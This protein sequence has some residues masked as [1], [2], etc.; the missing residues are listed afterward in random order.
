[1]PGGEVIRPF[2]QRRNEMEQI[3]RSA[4]AAA[5]L[6]LALAGCQKVDEAPAPQTPDSEAPAPEIN[7][8]VPE[9]APAPQININPSEPAPAPEININ[10]PEPAPGEG[11][12]PPAQ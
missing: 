5:V 1:M 6:A 3:T 11:A 2:S 7:I 8:N 4:L 10:V 9:P 12:P